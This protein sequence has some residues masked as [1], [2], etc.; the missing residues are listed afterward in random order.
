MLPAPTHLPYSTPFLIFAIGLTRATLKVQ[1]LR[2]PSMSSQQSVTRSIKIPD[3]LRLERFQRNPELGPSVLFFSGGSALK[4]LSKAITRY[5]KNSV[6]LLTP[7]DSG[8]SSAVLRDAFNMPAVGDM[9]SRLMALADDSVTGNPSVYQLANYRLPTDQSRQTLRA[10]LES[11]IEGVHPLITDVKDPL[12]KLIRL[13]L[14]YFLEAMPESFDLKGASVG[15]LI[16]AGGFLNYQHHLDPIL[17]LFSQLLGVQGTV[18]PITDDNYHLAVSL[19]DGT[20][21]LGQHRFTGKECCP[22]SSPIKDI[23]LSESIEN[24]LPV[25]SSL[26]EQIAQHIVEADLIC[27]PPGSF[28]S[29]I[30]ANLLPKGVGKAVAENEAPKVYVPS[31]GTDP[32]MYGVSFEQSVEKLLHYLK[33]SD[34]Q[35]RDILRYLNILLVDSEFASGISEQAKAAWSEQGIQI[36]ETPLTSA[37]SRPYYDEQ[38]LA[39]AL[40]S[41][42]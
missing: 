33:Q 41:L 22:I 31:L 35:Q 27:Y 9:R 3:A 40:L 24:D 17:F 18:R 1:P 37:S 6:H 5:T 28:Y 7:F 42:T 29:S 16:L 25:D 13:Q 10:I 19:E 32:E 11:M 23:W 36:I 12:G 4:G 39:K 15:N 38:L 2:F 21:I 30:V 20:K 8:G 34:D 26:P 14:G